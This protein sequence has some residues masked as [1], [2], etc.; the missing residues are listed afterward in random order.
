[1]IGGL[2]VNKWMGKFLVKKG[3]KIVLCYV[4]CLS[5]FGGGLVW[6]MGKKDKGKGVN[7]NCVLYVFVIIIIVK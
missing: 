2:G 3:I 1:M 4:V 7:L 5:L 6:G